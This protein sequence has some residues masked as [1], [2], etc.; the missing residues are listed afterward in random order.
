MLVP[1]VVKEGRLGLLAIGVDV[2][3]ATEVRAEVAALGDLIAVALER[4]RLQREAD[5]QHDLRESRLRFFPRRVVV[6]APGGEPGDLLRS[7]A[8]GC[9]RPIAC[10]CGCTTAGHGCSSSSPRPTSAELAARQRVAVRRATCRSPTAMRGTGAALTE[11]GP[12]DGPPTILVPL[13]GR[14]RALGTLVVRSVRAR[15]GR[16]DRRA[17]S[18][19]GSR[20]AALDRHRECLAPRGR[21]ALA[22]RAREHVQLARRSRRR[23]RRRAAGHALQPGVCLATRAGGRKS[24]S[25]GHSPSSS[26][27]TW[28]SWIE[29]PGASANPRASEMQ[30]Q[31]LEDPVLGGTFIFTVSRSGRDAKT[32]ASAP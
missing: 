4:A 7:R 28:C 6:A 9:S 11:P 12:A 16:R 23:Q 13:R 1:L 14:R 20:P 3:R 31:E 22:A 25:A 29:R 5:L 27:T 26:A 18:A 30:T 10:R 2:T 17:R 19:R 32:N 21:A 15:G 8:R 24:S